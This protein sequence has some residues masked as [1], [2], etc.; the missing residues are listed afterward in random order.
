[1]VESSELPETDRMAYL[2]AL[3]PLNNN[4]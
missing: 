2:T 3:K 1:M 4:R